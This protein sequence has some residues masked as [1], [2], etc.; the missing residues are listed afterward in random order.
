MMS[1]VWHFFINRIKSVDLLRPFQEI[2]SKSSRNLL[3]VAAGNSDS[4]AWELLT[5]CH[6]VSSILTSHPALGNY[7]TDSSYESSALTE[8]CANS[9]PDADFRGAWLVHRIDKSHL[10]RYSLG[11]SPPLLAALQF[12][13][14]ETIHAMVSRIDEIDL[15]APA[16][17]TKHANLRFNPSLFVGQE[18]SANFE[19][20]EEFLEDPN[21]YVSPALDS[22]VSVDAGLIRWRQDL[23][24]IAHTLGNQKKQM[25]FV[26]QKVY[27]FLICFAGFPKEIVHICFT[28]GRFP[29]PA[30]TDI[31]N[32]LR[33]WK[34]QQE[35]ILQ[36]KLRAAKQRVINAMKTKTENENLNKKQK[37]HKRPNPKVPKFFH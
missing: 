28:Y 9:S 37:Y 13:K 16:F 14:K 25:G 12:D 22:P 7:D 31:E 11:G 6:E 1:N 15:F 23:D 19:A 30:C 17:Y 8:A 3:A 27:P 21:I 24:T 32:N 29:S 36:Q 34:P 26:I 10:N 35:V 18:L 4:Y 2:R 5:R 20:L 33:F